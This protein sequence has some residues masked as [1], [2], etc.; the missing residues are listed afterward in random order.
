[1]NVDWLNIITA[2][3]AWKQRLQKFLDGTSTETLD[4]AA[5]AVDNRCEL[6]KWIYSVG[7]SFQH[8]A[9]YSTVKDLHAS[10]HKVAANI[11]SHHLRGDTDVAQSL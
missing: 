6:G 7:M 10:F 4:P 2:H 9:S 8:T 11:V 3:V 5:I 1:M